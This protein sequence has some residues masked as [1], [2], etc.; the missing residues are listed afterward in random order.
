M[1]KLNKRRKLLLAV[2][3]LV[4]VCAIGGGIWFAV[5]RTGSDPVLVYP[6]QYLGMT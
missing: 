5:S 6:F 2:I 1:K 4:L 3:S